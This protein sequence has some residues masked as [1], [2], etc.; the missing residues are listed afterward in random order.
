MDVAVVRRLTEALKGLGDDERRY[1][2]RWLLAYYG[3]DARMLS[4]AQPGLPRRLALDGN[5]YLLVATPAERK[6]KK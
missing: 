5:T 6:P 3:D 4:P 1:V 2:V